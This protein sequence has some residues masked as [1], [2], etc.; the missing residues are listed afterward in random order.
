LLAVYILDRVAPDF[1]IMGWYANRIL[2][3][4]AILVGVAACSGYGIAAWFAGL[5]ISGKLV[6]TIF[7][8]QTCAYFGAQYIEFHGLHLIHRDT[9]TPVGFWEY[10][11]LMARSFAWQQ[12]DGTH[13]EAL[14]IYGYFFRVIEILGFSVGGLI[15]PI[16][17]HSNPYCEK[18]LRYK[19]TRQLVYVPASIPIK[20]ISKK[21]TAA[22]EAQVAELQKAMDAGK[23]RV[24][25]LQ[26]LATAGEADNFL[27]EISAIKS[28]N[29]KAFALPIRYLI[30][31]IHC[32]SCR[33][34]H[35]KTGQL[36]GQ[37]NQFK[38]TEIG[39]TPLAEDF[40]QLV[41]PK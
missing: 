5:K 9:N 24:E 33:A 27:A 13:G 4:G 20:K 28:E 14:G 15:V 32:P 38:R 41:R 22:N 39:T 8:L 36:V 26:A 35:L 21:D 37:G 6:L 17:M 40:V 1:N 23:Q 10:F 31:L 34:G 3:I 2:P 19:R 29:K 25:A 30:E 7:A 16:A 18:C 12:H 11:N